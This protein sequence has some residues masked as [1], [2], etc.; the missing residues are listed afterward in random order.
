MPR[1]KV[2]RNE[3]CPCGSGKKYKKCC[4]SKDTVSITDVIDHEIL[5][6]QKEARMFAIKRFEYEIVDDFEDLFQVLDG[7]DEEDEDFYQFLHPFWFLVFEPLEDGKTIMQKFIEYKLGKVSRKRVRAILQS[8]QDG[9][10]VAGVIKEYQNDSLIIEDTLTGRRFPVVLFEHS[11]DYEEGV[12]AFAILHHYEDKFTVFPTLFELSIKHTVDYEAFIKS[13]FLNSGYD[14]PEEFLA[15]NFLEMMYETPK[16]GGLLDLS[17]FEWPSNGAKTVAEIFEKDMKAAGEL[18]WIIQMGVI[19]WME[20]CK[21][22]NK[23]IQ[24]PGNYVAA[25]RYL[26][27]TLSPV[28]VELTQKQIGEIYEI[29]ANRVSSYYSEIYFVVEDQIG[30][31]F[32]HERMNVG[33][34]LEIT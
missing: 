13:E 1:V 6:L 30:S 5:E 3:P 18:N 33:H 7:A 9:Y 34:S 12:F 17:S 29:P 27:S 2:S 23:K 26:V 32:E 22:T 31:M 14:S 19:L 25:L 21:Q 10:A 16:A 8:W 28:N 24:K 20:Y 11:R 4:G 15:D